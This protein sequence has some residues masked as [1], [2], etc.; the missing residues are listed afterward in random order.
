M[1]D[2]TN[3]N[4]LDEQLHYAVANSKDINIIKNLLNQGASPLW[5][6]VLGMTVLHWADSS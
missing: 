4:D 6:S 3:L 5:K 1:S 2:N